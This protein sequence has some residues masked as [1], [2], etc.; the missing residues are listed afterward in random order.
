MKLVSLLVALVPFAGLAQ[1]VA[2]LAPHER[3][4]GLVTKPELGLSEEWFTAVTSTQPQR[5]RWVGEWVS[6]ALPFRFRYGGSD[7]NT[8]L[9]NWRLERGSQQLAWTDPATGLP[10]TWS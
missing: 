5:A 6:S 3:E 7:S 2:S 8:F 10:L 9:Q 1:T 4:S